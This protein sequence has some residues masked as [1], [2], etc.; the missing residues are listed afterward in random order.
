MAGYRVVWKGPV[1][2]A[3][4]LGIASREY[5]KALKRQG[6]DVRVGASEKS[7]YRDEKTKKRNVLIYHHLPTTI[8]FE[9][10]R[11]QFD[12]IILNTV[13]ETTRIPKSWMRVMNKFDAVL[14]PSIQNKQ[15]MRNSGVKV[16]VFLV[17]HGVHT[18]KYNPVNKKL[19]LQQAKGR[20]VFVSVF[21]FQHRK[22]PETLLRAY[23]E[24]FSSTD[25][26][27]LV[28]K[29]NGYAP[30]EDE[31]WIKNRVS[32]YKKQLGLRKSTAP[33]VILGRRLNDKQMTGIYTLGHAFVLPT[34]GEGVGLPFLESLASGVPVITT[35]W[36]GHMD[37]LTK[38]NSF[39][40]SYKLR[41]PAGSM[42]QKSA[43]SRRF[44]QLFAEKGQQWA[45]PDISSLKH[46]MRSAY[47]QPLLCKQK[48]RQGRKDSLA[49]SWNR[50]GFA[51]KKA[52]EAVIRMKK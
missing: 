23:W 18:S 45:E 38:K 25:K 48:G 7:S 46:Q 40:V 13:W 5:A 31:A 24:Q 11:K 21:G 41:N 43:I 47:N 2:K 49:L 26:A 15:A 6:V 33:V 19:P 34:R 39:F 3:S 50:A 12:L 37:F 35:G 1:Q 8:N 28:I 17:P 16:P 36:G 44:R 42:N 32:R 52:V 4:G 30:S 9:K 10:E 51:L 29:T 27:L 20:F 14:V 22:N